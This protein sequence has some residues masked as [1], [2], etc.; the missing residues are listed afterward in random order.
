M[1]W[2]VLVTLAIS[3]TKGLLAAATKAQLPQEILDSLQAAL[4]AFYKVHGTEV[5]KSQLELLRIDAPFG[6]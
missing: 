6:G 3:L 2:T 1:D 5:T 4:D